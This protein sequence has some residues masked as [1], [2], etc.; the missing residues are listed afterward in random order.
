MRL[1]ILGRLATL[2]AVPIKRRADEVLSEFLRN[3]AS[4]V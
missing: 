2:G 3:V 1:E 4:S